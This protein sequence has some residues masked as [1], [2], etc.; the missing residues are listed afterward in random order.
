ML[1]PASLQKEWHR[2]KEWQFHTARAQKNKVEWML[3]SKTGH[4]NTSTQQAVCSL[5]SQLLMKPPSSESTNLHWLRT[6]CAA[7]LPQ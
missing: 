4:R 3:F 2:R 5:P 6:G 1:R 7:F